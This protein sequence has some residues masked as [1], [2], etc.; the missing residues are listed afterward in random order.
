MKTRT[1][2]LDLLRRPDVTISRLDAVCGYT[3]GKLDTITREALRQIEIEAK[4]GGYLSRQQSQIEQ[5]S[6]LEN[7]AI[8]R[9][10]DYDCVKGI[11]YESREKFA[12]V[13]PE[14]IGQAGR[15]PGIRPTDVAILI[16]HLRRREKV[17][18]AYDN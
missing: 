16:G 1:P 7:L 10:F 14:T 4:Y 8:P 12:R 15:I 17:G 11:S 2:L 3:N 18:L 9:D 5:L 13:R 6:R